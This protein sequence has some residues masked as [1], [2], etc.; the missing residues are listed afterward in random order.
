VLEQISQLGQGLDAFRLEPLL[1][2]L[3]DVQECWVPTLDR[4]G[5]TDAVVRAGITLPF[6]PIAS[7]LEGLLG[8]F[9][10]FTVSFQQPLDF[11]CPGWAVDF[12]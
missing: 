8:Q 12:R 6:Q 11:G 5:E 9:V 3:C 2:P 4:R 1:I 7:L 10:E